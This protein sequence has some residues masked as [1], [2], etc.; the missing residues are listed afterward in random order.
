MPDRFFIKN[1]CY[2]L[3]MEYI[4]DVAT[5]ATVLFR[6]CK[7]TEKHIACQYRNITLYLTPR[8]PWSSFLHP[9][10]QKFFFRFN[11]IIDESFDYYQ[12]RSITRTPQS[13][14][15]KLWEIILTCRSKILYNI[16]FGDKTLVMISGNSDCSNAVDHSDH[17]D[18]V[19]V[20]FKIQ[21]T[22]ISFV[23]Y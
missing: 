10:N 14:L 5:N 17:R 2:L 22:F 18:L 4:K 6:L 12:R 21:N 9:S 3:Q 7:F 1:E 19:C 8:F 20:V 16:L 11:K 15:I 23:S 13:V